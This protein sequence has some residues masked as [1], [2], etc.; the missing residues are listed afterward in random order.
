MRSTKRKQLSCSEK[1]LIEMYVK[2]FLKKEIQKNGQ[3]YCEP[4]DDVVDYFYKLKIALEQ[5]EVANSNTTRNLK[6]FLKCICFLICLSLIA[7][8]ILTITYSDG[9]KIV[10]AVTMI[11]PLLIIVVAMKFLSEMISDMSKT[12]TYNAFMVVIAIL[13]IMITVILS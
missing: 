7:I 10:E 13:S 12:D 6:S 4:T 8:V 3:L 11:L 2:D 5:K 9:I 1:E